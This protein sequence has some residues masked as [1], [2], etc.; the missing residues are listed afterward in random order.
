MFFLL[1]G[2]VSLVGSPSRSESRRVMDPNSEWAQ[3][4]LVLE[5][6]PAFV[7]VQLLFCLLFVHIALELYSLYLSIEMFIYLYICICK[8]L[9]IYISISVYLFIYISI[10]L[11]PCGLNQC[12]AWMRLRSPPRS[13][14]EGATSRCAWSLVCQPVVSKPLLGGPGHL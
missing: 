8:S 1:L 13:T 12:R 5:V 11:Y 6:L 10:Y 7:L 2:V 3:A 4:I 9:Y 14:K